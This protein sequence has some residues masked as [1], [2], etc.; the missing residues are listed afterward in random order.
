MKILLQFEHQYEV[1]QIWE[2]S[3]L[4]G[5]T[6]KL[7]YPGA[8]E[9]GGTDGVLLKIVP[10]AGDTWI[11]N[12]APG[13]PGHNFINQVMSC[14]NPNEVCVI[15]SGAGYIVQVDN[16]SNWKSVRSIPVCDALAVLTKRLLVLSDFT[17]L[18]AYGVDGLKWESTDVSSDGIQ[19][20]DIADE[21]L[22]LIGWDAAQQ[23]KVCVSVSLDD[24]SILSRSVA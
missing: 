8:S 24:G 5:G 12:F 2:T 21:H 1:E 6:R 19:V 20:T 13:H 16:P 10:V 3:G 11:G 18:V 15:Y 22:G 14:P 17:R 23:K 9:T 4:P 7:F